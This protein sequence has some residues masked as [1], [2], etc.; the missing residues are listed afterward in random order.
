VGLS[1]SGEEVGGD[2]SA[3]LASVQAAT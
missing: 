3:A 2:W 1:A